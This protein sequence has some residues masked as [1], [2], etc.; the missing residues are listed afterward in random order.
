MGHQ[1]VIYTKNIEEEMSSLEITVKKT[2]IGFKGVQ[3]LSSV[4]KSFDAKCYPDT[5]VSINPTCGMT[6]ILKGWYERCFKK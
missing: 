1:C 2:I 4:V 3:K 6:D 5:N